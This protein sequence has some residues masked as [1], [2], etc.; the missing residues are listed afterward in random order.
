MQRT[1]KKSKTPPMVVRGTRLP[2]EE[3]A[4]MNQIAKMLK[5][6]VSDILR[7]AWTE[8]VANH[9]LRKALAESKAKRKS[10]AK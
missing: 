4:E 2:K 3:A 8:H 6:T 9:N 7:T 10:K 1:Q 5:R